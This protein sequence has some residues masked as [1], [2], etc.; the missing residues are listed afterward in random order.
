[1]N[2][3][4]HVIAVVGPTA[5]G[6]SSLA[7]RLALSLGSSVVSIDAMQVYRGMDIGT[8]KTP[9]MERRVELHMIDVCDFTEDYSAQRFQTDARSV[10][11]ALHEQG[12]TP[13]L[14]GGTG[15]YLDAVIDEMDFPKGQ[16]GN[17]TRLAYEQ[18]LAERGSDYLYA[19]L[20]ERDPSSALLIH[21]NNT[22]RV[23][24]ALELLDEGASYATQHKGLRK[25]APHYAC[26][27]Y[28][29]AMSRDTLYTRIDARVDQM[30]CQGLVHEVEKLVERGLKNSK[31][32]SQAIGYK[33]VMAYLDGLCSLDEARALIKQ[34]SRRYAKRQ[35]SWIKRDGRAKVLD[36]DSMNES[37]AL[38]I[39]LSESLPQEKGSHA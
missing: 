16:V 26:T 23:I 13:V 12:R 10:V 29:I 7:D 38:G 3:L 11:D 37:D 14:C 35:I 24:R 8:A 1:M 17:P 27:M 6:K 32:A 15:L 5:S 19:Q 25:R 33:E 2:E 39:I 34:R 21:P 22:R 20:S 28:A 30:F 36:Y 4:H 9:K 31:T 18:L